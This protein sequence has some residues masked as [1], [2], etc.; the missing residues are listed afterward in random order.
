MLGKKAG[1]IQK[2]LNY[3]TREKIKNS[4]EYNEES[5]LDRD[6]EI[7]LHSYYNR[8]GYWVNK[9]KSMKNSR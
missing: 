9:Q 3:L 4:P 8:P 2:A 5:L 1:T 7:E 6:Y